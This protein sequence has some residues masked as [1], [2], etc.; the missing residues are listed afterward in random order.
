MVKGRFLHILTTEVFVV[1]IVL[2]QAGCLAAFLVFYP[3]DSGRTP[4]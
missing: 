2:G 3:P 1:D 4:S